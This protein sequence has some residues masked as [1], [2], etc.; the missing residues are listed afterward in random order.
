MNFRKIRHSLGVKTLVV[1][2]I[3][4]GGITLMTLPSWGS[5]SISIDDF[6]IS[7]SDL[8]VE[9]V[10]GLISEGIFGW[11]AT[12]E[13]SEPGALGVPDPNAVAKELEDDLGYKA[14]DEIHLYDQSL[15]EIFSSD[16]LS[17][18]NQDKQDQAIKDTQQ[19]VAE[20]AQDAQLAQAEVVTQEVMKHLA[21]QQSRNSF[22][23][24]TIQGDMSDVNVKTDVGN[25]NLSNISKTLDQ[26]RRDEEQ[27]QQAR[28][29]AMLEI[30]GYTQLYK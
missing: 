9:D 4:L 30:L 5:F 23:L 25:R 18:E 8:N 2:S 13:T 26:Q 7:S 11:G 3:I 14:W 16:T 19:K 12:P 6:T 28:S 20:S 27:D 15:A 21:N 22:I 24:G 17:D 1:S 10:W 29:N